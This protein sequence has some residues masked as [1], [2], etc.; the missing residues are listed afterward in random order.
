MKSVFT[1]SQICSDSGIQYQ[2]RISLTLSDWSDINVITV[3][4]IFLA[5]QCFFPDSN[6]GSTSIPM[7]SLYYVILQGKI[8]EACCFYQYH[9]S[10]RDCS[11]SDFNVH[12]SIVFLSKSLA[13]H[14]FT[15]PWILQTHATHCIIAALDL[16]AVMVL[17]AA[18]CLKLTQS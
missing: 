11:L 10:F 17:L 15:L 13:T 14:F 2:L 18:T 5:F 3:I 4:L 6:G 9:Q 12:F 8:P 1:D 16:H 7:H